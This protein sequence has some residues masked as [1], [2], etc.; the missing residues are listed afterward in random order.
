MN[1]SV[2]R[3]VRPVPVLLLAVVAL[4][5]AVLAGGTGTH[6]PAHAESHQHDVASAGHALTAQQAAFHDQMRKLWEDHVTWTRLA[7]VTF[8]D[9]SD[10]FAPTASRL[11][12]NQVDI[13]DALEPFYGA[14]AGDTLTALLHD[15]ITIAVE[16]L[17]AARNGDDEAFATAR[18]RWYANSDAVSDH[19]S[20]L[21]PK[22]WPRP[23]VRAMMRTHLDQT[24]TEAADELGGDYPGSVAAYDAIHEHILEMADTLSAGII[25]QFPQHFRR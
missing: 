11:L 5:V 16:L 21:N 15:H 8:A 10:G 13:G 6:D 23:V 17:Q 4:L 3:T 18:G 20:S 2:H 9:G 22:A 19:L 25:S 1:R 7:I 14:R 12:Q 24:L